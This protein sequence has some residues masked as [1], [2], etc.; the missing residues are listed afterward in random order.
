M[1]DALECRNK[2]GLLGKWILHTRIPNLKKPLL[3]GKICNLRRGEVR[4]SDDSP[5]VLRKRKPLSRI[6]DVSPHRKG[7]AMD[8]NPRDNIGQHTLVIDEIACF[9][10]N[11]VIP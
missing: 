1:L 9:A 7:T 8:R 3:I 4:R 5:R 2:N 10:D 6:L 11:E